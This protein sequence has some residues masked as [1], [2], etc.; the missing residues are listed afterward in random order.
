M[1]EVKLQI[2]GE[3]IHVIV[4]KCCNISK[5]LGQLTPGKI[6]VIGCKRDSSNHLIESQLFSLGLPYLLINITLSKN[7]LMHIRPEIDKDLSPFL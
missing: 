7:A 5:M 1:L 2:E 4:G 3:V 6:L